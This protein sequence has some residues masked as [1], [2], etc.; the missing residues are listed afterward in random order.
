MDTRF[1]TLA[2]DENGVA[3]LTLNRPDKFN[4]L[5]RD[6]VGDLATT[7][8]E[9]ARNQKIRV[10]IV[11]EAGPAFCAGGD[12]E[13]MIGLG[14]LGA[15]DWALSVKAAF[16]LVAKLEIPV[17]AALNGPAIG[18]GC[19]LALA[20]DIRIASEKAR[21]GQPEITLGIIPGAGGTQRLARTIGLSRA[22][23][24]IM[25]GRIIRPE[26]ALK[27]GL[28][29]K[30]VE[31]GQL[32]QEVTDLAKTIAKQSALAVRL[33]KSLINSASDIPLEVGLD[34]EVR[35]FAL[36]F[37]SPEQKEAMESFLKRKQ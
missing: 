15:R 35:G 17:I 30:V 7:L 2:E 34:N 13:G 28:I 11:T 23:E 6:L 33:A 18:G 8:E 4:A 10:L 20:C 37:G 19:E 25:T 5:N 32:D 9:V 1:V 24:L 27:I 22:K 31:D 14:P 12:I 29:D 3:R 26:E 36:T 21:F 16:D